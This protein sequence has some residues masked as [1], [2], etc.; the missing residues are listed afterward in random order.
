[1]KSEMRMEKE[2]SKCKWSDKGGEIKKAAETSGK[3]VTKAFPNRALTH[4]CV[5]Y[6]NSNLLPYK[7]TLNAYKM[8][9]NS[10][11]C[12]FMNEIFLFK[13]TFIY[14]EEIF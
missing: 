7:I 2:G 10:I 9:F 12:S 3:P 6:F 11:D 1:M 8:I 14:I 5:Y 4:I 13:F